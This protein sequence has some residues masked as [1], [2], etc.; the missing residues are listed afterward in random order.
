MLEE[1]KQPKENFPAPNTLFLTPVGREC[2]QKCLTR[3]EMRKA[4]TTVLGVLD[5]LHKMGWCHCDVRWPNVILDVK[6]GADGGNFVLTDFEYARKTGET[7][8]PVKKDFIHPEILETGLWH[9]FGDTHQVVLMIK[10]WMETHKDEPDLID[11]AKTLSTKWST[12]Q[13]L[14]QYLLQCWK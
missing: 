11:V 7:C 6:G 13:T 1:Q 4:I 9:E 2:H 12:S 3:D 5:K 10:G 8:P 14:L